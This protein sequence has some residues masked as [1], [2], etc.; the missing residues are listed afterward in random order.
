MSADREEIRWKFQVMI[1][2]TKF[3]I[4]GLDDQWKNFDEQAERSLRK[5]ERKRNYRLTGLGFTITAILTLVATGKFGDYEQVGIIVAGILGLYAAVLF[6][7]SEHVLGKEE[8]VQKEIND[9]FFDAKTQKFI[10]A[11]GKIA[12]LAMDKTITEEQMEPI[13]N[14]VSLNLKSKDYLFGWK[15]YKI[16]IKDLSKEQR[17]EIDLSRFSHKLYEETYFGGKR[18]LD[19][20]KKSTLNFD[21][22]DIEEFIKS[23][24]KNVKSK[25]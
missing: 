19:L 25:T 10:P 9:L 11:M 15:L 16:L 4:D 24:E 7:L 20:F 18:E 14:Y 6:G 22:S 8:L 13:Q 23:Y 3:V 5:I 2:N 12:T 1:E 17:K 21:T